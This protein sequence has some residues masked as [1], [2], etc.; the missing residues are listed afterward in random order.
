[1]TTINIGDCV[2]RNPKIVRIGKTYD[3]GIG[4]YGKVFDM[5]RQTGEKYW[6]VRIKWTSGHKSSW[7][8][9]N[10]LR[11][12]VEASRSKKGQPWYLV[13]EKEDK[14]PALGVLKG[15]LK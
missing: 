12:V 13:L 11:K 15:V 10:E 2:S 7:I 8:P 4:N 14:L 3:D 6:R 1:M 9:D 5:G